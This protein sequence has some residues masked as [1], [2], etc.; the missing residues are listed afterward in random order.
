[1]ETSTL[2]YNGTVKLLFNKAK[3]HYTLDG[4]TIDGVTSIIGIKNKPALVAWAA[5]MAAEY[6]KNHIVAGKALD[7]IEIQQLVDGAKK[8]HRDFSGKAMNYGT[9]LHSYIEQWCIADINYRKKY[10]AK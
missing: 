2:H 6:V 7:E 3:H 5:N 8:A 10:E 9:A 1:M 4:K